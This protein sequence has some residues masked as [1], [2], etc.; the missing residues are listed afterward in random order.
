MNG[1]G[2]A[3]ANR[4][5]G[6]GQTIALPPVISLPK[7]GGA[8]RGISYDSG[9]DNGSYGLMQFSSPVPACAA[10]PGK[11]TA[12]LEISTLPKVTAKRRS[13]DG[14]KKKRE[15]LIQPEQVY[16]KTN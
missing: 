10:A 7:R 13:G 11:L 15:T 5:S 12:F 4:V 3:D 9:A 16:E 1:I 14:E 6:N 8:I 2:G